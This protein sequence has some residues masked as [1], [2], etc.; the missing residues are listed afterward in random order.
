ML[1]EMVTGQ[2]PYEAE[3]P[4]AVVLK[5]ISAPLP[6]PRNVNPDV[7]EA[8][9]R[10]ILRAMAKD[11][12]DRFQT[13]GEMIAALDRAVRGTERT[14]MP[15]LPDRT[16]TSC[17]RWRSLALW[18]GIGVAAAIALA[19]LLA[20]GLP[21][22]Q[23]RRQERM[24]ATAI[25][26]L[27]LTPTSTATQSPTTTPTA[28]R[29]PTPTAT[30]TPTP[31]V[32]NTPTPTATSTP[33]PT[34]TNTPT[35]TAT[36][37]PTP[38]VTNTPTITPTPTQ[39]YTPTPSPAQRARAF[40]EPILASIADRPPDY[41]DDFSNPGSG[42]GTG[43][44]DEGQGGYKDGRYFVLAKPNAGFA[45]LGDPWF[46][47]FV[48]EV[49]VHHVSGEGTED[50]WFVILRDWREPSTSPHGFYALKGQPNDGLSHL[51]MHNRTKDTTTELF[52][53]LRPRIN[54]AYSTTHV[55]VVLKGP[56]IAV[57]FNGSPAG[58]GYDETYR[59]GKVGMGAGSESGTPIEVHFD[60]LKIWDISGLP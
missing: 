19:L 7:P 56:W 42:W 58:I 6:L 38:T 12:H 20:W 27:K 22:L 33:T 13:V 10:V 36:N 2:V 5:H 11:P 50:G 46:A 47:D 15:S 4:L 40:A 37:T 60:N 51:R 25:A 24:T 30:S 52:G 29:T 45:T 28:S 39:T 35:P 17:V 14:E 44:S 53:H 41:Q 18:G 55:L 21:A 26:A 23:D 54:G 49:D 43:T 34:V 8:V 32:T 9:E 31:T 57:Y 16:R 3:T 59:Q 1:Y 48:L